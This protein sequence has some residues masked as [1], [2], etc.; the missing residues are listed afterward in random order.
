MLKWKRFQKVL[1]LESNAVDFFYFFLLFLLL[2]FIVIHQL[3]PTVADVVL[4]HTIV[5]DIVMLL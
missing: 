3:L 4:V 1:S 5:D 2:L